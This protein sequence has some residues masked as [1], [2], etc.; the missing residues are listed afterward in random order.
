MKS[1]F[2]A[3]SPRTRL[4]EPSRKFIPCVVTYL[5]AGYGWHKNWD[6]LLKISLCVDAGLLKVDLISSSGKARYSFYTIV[7]P[8][9]NRRGVV[10]TRKSVLEIGFCFSNS[11]NQIEFLKY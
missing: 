8:S 4:L 7:C 3:S 6:P 9:V 2:R 5:L 1:D 11:E 10:T